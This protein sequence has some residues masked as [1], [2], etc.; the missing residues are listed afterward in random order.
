MDALKQDYE[1]QYRTLKAKEVLIDEALKH[2][3]KCEAN[4]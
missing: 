2:Y 3:R 4:Q 1:E